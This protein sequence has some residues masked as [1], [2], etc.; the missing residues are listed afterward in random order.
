[1]HQNKI[2]APNLFDIERL[3]RYRTLAQYMLFH[4][5]LGLSFVRY[6]LSLI[7]I[8]CADRKLTPVTSGQ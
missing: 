3:K 8:L 2:Q 7:I 4:F 5:P 1:M 6:L